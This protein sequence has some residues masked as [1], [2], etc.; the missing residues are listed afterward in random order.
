MKNLVALLALS[1]ILFA[2]CKKDD[3]NNPEPSTPAPGNSFTVEKKNMAAIVYFGEDWCPPCGAY[4]G[5]TMDSCLKEEGSKL[6][7]IKVNS[8]S[9]NQSLNWSVGN[10][11]YGAYNQGLFNNASTI[12][13]MGVN[14]VEQPIYT[15]INTNYSQVMN[16]VNAFVADP[17]VAGI[18]LQKSITGDSIQVDT[19]VKFFQAI[20]AGSDYRLGIYLLENNIVASQSVSGSGTVAGY[21]H[22][23]LVRASNAPVYTG[24]VVNNSQAITLDQEFTAT[25]KMYLK[26]AWNRSNLKVV[27][28]LWKMGTTPAKVVNSYV[29]K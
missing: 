9:N 7:A 24:V 16:K 19:K 29:L 18:A 8:S 20:A 28:I 11:M 1:C 27:A 4:G 26:P 3:D 25:Y 22:H 15:S 12:P 6:T 2:G 5:P 21:V 23:N 14:N 10:G 13:A 17:V